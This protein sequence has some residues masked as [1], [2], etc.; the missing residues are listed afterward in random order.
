MKIMP[1]S[2]LLEIKVEIEAWLG[3][4]SFILSD[5]MDATD[6]REQFYTQ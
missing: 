5:E 3:N 1:N 2:V 6:L 4:L